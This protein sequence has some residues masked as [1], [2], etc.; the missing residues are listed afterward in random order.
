LGAASTSSI[1]S[2]IEKVAAPGDPA[3][4]SNSTFDDAWDPNLNNS[5]VVF[6]GHV[7]G[8]ICVGGVTAPLV[9]SIA[10]TCTGRHRRISSIA[11]QGMSAPGGGKFRYTFNGRLN[12]GAMRALSAR[13]DAKPNGVFL[14]LRKRPGTLLAVARW[15]IRYLAGDE[16]RNPVSGFSCH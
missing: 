1:G 6:G 15:A 3:P 11:H 16:K 7:T 10:F 4:G 14:F 8:E 5:D 12:E 13:S 2:T 9:A